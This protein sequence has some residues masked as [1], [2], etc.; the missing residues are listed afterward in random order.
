MISLISILISSCSTT[1]PQDRRFLKSIGMD[2]FFN[3]ELVEKESEV[4]FT[5]DKNKKTKAIKK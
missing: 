3:K 2:E 1:R 4:Q 5:T